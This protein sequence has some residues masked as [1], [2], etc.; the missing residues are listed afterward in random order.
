MTTEHNIIK[1]QGNHLG[2]L[3]LEVVFMRAQVLQ[4]N[5]MGE[6]SKALRTQ[7][8]V[9]NKSERGNSFGFWNSTAQAVSFQVSIR[10]SG[11]RQDV[12]TCMYCIGS[13][14]VP[15]LSPF[16][17]PS[18]FQVVLVQFLVI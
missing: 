9:R 8:R 2:P 16:L 6:R 14:L 11:F 5:F 13:Y 15:L 12:F 3:C 18:L 7:G 4:G 17:V 1:F 10:Y